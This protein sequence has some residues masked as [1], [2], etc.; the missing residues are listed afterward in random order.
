MSIRHVS[1][2]LDHMPELDRLEAFVLIAIADSADKDSG[3]GW[4][5]LATIA[6]RARCTRRGAQKALRRL[7][8]GAYF[9]RRDNVG[10]AATY[11]LLFDPDGKRRTAAELYPTRERRSQG[12]AN[13]V[14]K[15]GEPRAGGGEPGSQG[16]RTADTPYMRTVF[17]PSLNP[18][19]SKRRS[20]EKEPEKIDREATLKTLRERMGAP[21]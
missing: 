18:R 7:E 6:K 16:G 1:A 21:T 4:P 20:P 9:E 3:V 19:A 10:R 13:P 14:R 11:R 17:D 8:V 12:G 2:V 15:G 5:S